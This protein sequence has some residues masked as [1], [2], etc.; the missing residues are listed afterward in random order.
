MEPT[1]RL[2]ALDAVRAFALLL[3][4]VLHASAAFLQ[5]FPIPMWKDQP[6]TTA[7]V[8]YYTIHM[9]YPLHWSV[10]LIV[11]VGGSL[12]LLLLSYHYWAR[13]TWIGAVLNGR[14]HPRTAHNAVPPANASAS[15]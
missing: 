9:F 8:I 10:K 11:M 15:L 7:A 4:V 6:S 1:D 13:F 12:P 14:R 3:G 2:H 5:D